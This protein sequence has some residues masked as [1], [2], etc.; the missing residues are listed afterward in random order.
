MIDL[1]I[2][3]LI[4]NLIYKPYETWE[5]KKIKNV[6]LYWEREV[7]S[8]AIV[9]AELLRE[10][11]EEVEDFFGDHT[12]NTNFIL[13]FEEDVIKTDFSF[14]P[15]PTF[16][17]N[18]GGTRIEKSFQH[19]KS[20][21]D[22]VRGFL[23]CAFIRYIP[24]RLKII[25]P[26][27]IISPKH[28]SAFCDYMT[29]D[30]NFLNFPF[31]GSKLAGTIKF[32]EKEYGKNKVLDLFLNAKITFEGIRR[33]EDEFEKWRRTKFIYDHT[34]E[35]H[36]SKYHLKIRSENENASSEDR[37][38]NYLY[39]IQKFSEK[40]VTFLSG[41]LVVISED[42]KSYQK[43]IEL[44][45]PDQDFGYINGDGET[46]VFDMRKQN[47]FRI[48][49]VSKDLKVSEVKLKET[50]AWYPDIC[51]KKQLLVFVKKNIDHDELC[52][53]RL[54]GRND[55]ATSYY[56]CIFRT[57][58]YSEIFTPDISPDGKKVAFSI[59]HPN[60]F[61]DIFVIDLESGD[62][63]SVTQDRF[64]DI[65]PTWDSSNALIFSSNRTGPF[66]LFRFELD[67]NK[68]TRITN[69]NEGV[70]MGIAVSSDKTYGIAINDFS[71]IITSVTIQEH[72]TLSLKRESIYLRRYENTYDTKYARFTID[73]AGALIPFIQAKLPGFLLGR[74]TLF[75]IDDLLRNNIYFGFDW[76]LPFHRIQEVDIRGT[77][78]LGFFTNA[79]FRSINPQVFF[80]LRYIPFEGIFI[81]QLGKGYTFLPERK[82][83]SGLFLIYTFHKIWIFWGADLMNFEL[84]SAELPS[85]SFW[86]MVKTEYEEFGK[87]L[88]IVPRF[89]LLYRNTKK[90][91]Y[92]KDGAELFFSLSP[93]SSLT[94]L[95]SL[96]KTGFSASFSINLFSPEIAFL[97]FNM[98]LNGFLSTNVP[99]RFWETLGSKEIP[100]Y[101]DPPY[102]IGPLRKFSP[103]YFDLEQ[104]GYDIGN[105]KGVRIRRSNL[106]SVAS[107]K[108]YINIF[109]GY[110]NFPLE[111][112]FVNVVPFASFGALKTGKYLKFFPSYGVEMDVQ[113]LISFS[114]PL[115][116]RIGG[117]MGEVREVYFSVHITPGALR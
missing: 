89:G 2:L 7:S 16:L 111:L 35:H 3:S 66:N 14:S 1:L 21:R 50:R 58:R 84:I 19:I 117:A 92:L 41:D 74:F 26:D 42:L 94:N 20:Y 103:I 28:I 73:R 52:L 13:F 57:D 5:K 40:V 10:E 78:S 60:D 31:Y 81:R 62:K 9:F 85:S 6:D 44:D 87:G 97:I 61:F 38:S 46:L 110:F 109:R 101:F 18:L 11:I 64:V 65:F 83:S 113:T 27:S 100:L 80:K 15:S 53:L 4:F 116:L 76:R 114:L 12:P 59:R 90:S 71:P 39:G 43:L 72:E 69:H 79:I 45:V 96:E 106:G 22:I 48:Y 91:F 37:E 17:I 47:F 115:S 68:L 49:L 75:L 36:S 107:L 25:P 112:K 56:K 77:P 88:F 95:S 34:D 30:D 29:L 93:I 51:T 32:I 8:V 63:I 105:I 82:I 33:Y 102:D 98:A 108:T 104:L 86:N 55:S 23:G 67:T 70:F 54:S 99:K 24:R